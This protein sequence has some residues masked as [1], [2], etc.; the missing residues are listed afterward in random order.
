METIACFAL[1]VSFSAFFL[2]FSMLDRLTRESEVRRAAAPRDRSRADLTRARV[3][4]FTHRSGGFASSERAT[5]LYM[6]LSETR[7]TRDWNGA[8][9]SAPIFSVSGTGL[10]FVC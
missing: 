3:L 9:R 5:V 8:G 7:G 2:S 10:M 1:C 4:Q 6:E